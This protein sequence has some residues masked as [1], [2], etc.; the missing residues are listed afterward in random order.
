VAHDTVFE[1]DRGIE[2]PVIGAFF[3]EPGN[4]R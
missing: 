2:E 3:D 4:E 1:I